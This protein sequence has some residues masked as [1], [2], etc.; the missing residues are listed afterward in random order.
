MI[1]NKPIIFSFSILTVYCFFCSWYRSLTLCTARSILQFLDF[2]T[3]FLAH[4]LSA[5]ITDCS[6]F[7]RI[8]LICKHAHLN[9]LFR[10]FCFFSREDDARRTPSRFS[11]INPKSGVMEDLSLAKRGSFCIYFVCRMRQLLGLWRLPRCLRLASNFSH[12]YNYDS[13]SALRSCDF[14]A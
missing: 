14:L 9:C 12:D 3:N 2:F 4:E 7:R 6:F 1:F 8:I 13:S 11:L 10:S 5:H